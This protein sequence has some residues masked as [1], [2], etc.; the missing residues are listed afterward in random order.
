MAEDD[1]GNM[2]RNQIMQVLVDHREG[3]GLQVK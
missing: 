3:C 1:V 2:G